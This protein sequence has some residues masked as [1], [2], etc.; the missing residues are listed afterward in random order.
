MALYKRDFA[1]NTT[2]GGH[3]SERRSTLIKCGFFN[4]VLVLVS[5]EPVVSNDGEDE[6]NRTRQ[7]SRA[8]KD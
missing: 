5:A 4:A 7:F 3:M 6:F 1:L 2:R 8:S